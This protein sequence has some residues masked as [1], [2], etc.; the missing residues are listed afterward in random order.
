MSSE[1]RQIGME[2]KEKAAA[3]KSSDPCACC[4]QEYTEKCER[5]ETVREQD[6][7]GH[8]TVKRNKEHDR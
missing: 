4:H 7:Q 2:E 3:D 6:Q 5:A 1:D 8:W